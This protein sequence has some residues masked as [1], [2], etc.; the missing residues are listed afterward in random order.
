MNQK[1][2]NAW[3]QPLLQHLKQMEEIAKSSPGDSTMLRRLEDMAASLPSPDWTALADDLSSMMETSAADEIHTHVTALV[4]HMAAF[5]PIEN[6]V[7]KIEQKAPVVSALRTRELARVPLD[8][9]DRGQFSAGVE[10]IRVMANIQAKLLASIG[11]KREL[12]AN[13]KEAYV[14][15]DSFIRDMQLIAREEGLDT[16]KGNVLTNI[17]GERRLGLIYDMQTQSARGYARWKLDNDA[18]ALAVMPAWRLTDSTAR[19]PRGDWAQ[20]WARAGSAVGWSGASRTAFVALKTSPIWAKLSRFGTPWPP[21]DYGSTRDLEDVWRDEAEQLGLVKH[22]EK[23]E[24]VAEKNFNADLEASVAD[25]RPDQLSTLKLAF[26]DQV[27]EKKGRIVWQPDLIGKLTADILDN[28]LDRPFDNKRFKGRTANLGV[29]TDAAMRTAS[30]G[31]V[32]ISGMKM[33]ITPDTV[34]H[35]LDRH[36]EGREKDKS[37]RPLTNID[38]ECIPHVWRMPDRVVRDGSGVRFEKDIIGRTQIVNFERYKDGVFM[39][40]SVRVKY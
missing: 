25:W 8:L 17:A 16:G 1:K 36:G 4:A 7:R 21:F 11:Q 30:S 39:P 2:L 18:D 6:A 15:R 20:R 33:V 13:R 12:L 29:A 3:A 37:Q 5:G 38:I 35:M 27:A 34:Y 40:V 14:S 28:G 24:P 26:G 32:D 22:S 31:D 19:N 23:L 9:R 10:S